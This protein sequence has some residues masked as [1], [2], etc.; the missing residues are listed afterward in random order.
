[1][2][3]EALAYFDRVNAVVDAML[4][5]WEEVPLYSEIF[6]DEN[7]AASAAIEKNKEIGEKATGLLQKAI[8]KLKALFI[9]I[10]DAIGNA[11]EYFFASKEEKLDFDQFLKAA[12]EDPDLANKKV[13]FRDYRGILASMDKDIKNW[14]NEYTKFKES[15][16]ENNPS[17]TKT[18][19]SK[20]DEYTSTVGNILKGAGATVGM[21]VLLNAAKMN[22]Q[23]AFIIQ[24]AI[25]YDIGLLEAL[26]KQLG[27][28]RA[29]KFKK[30]IAKLNSSLEI[31]RKIHGGRELQGKTLMDA[32]KAI[33]DAQVLDSD[34]KNSTGKTVFSMLRMYM[35]ARGG[36]NKGDFKK[37][38]RGVIHTGVEG[39]KTAWK[40][41]NIV[42]EPGR[43]Q[44][45][46]DKIDK[47]A[48]RVEAK[49]E[50][51]K[52]RS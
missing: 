21:E 30:E 41:H 10:K 17:L 25:N 14:E 51:M 28:A 7:G 46:A 49:N 44:K 8:S 38:E 36:K 13:R 9:K 45:K 43:Q 5:E 48:R 18:I 31:V 39:V 22:R 11:L 2:L 33:T 52:N 40:V 32:F 16:A 47:K 26:E 1:M 20:M 19:S 12:K 50:K 37:A 29:K 4:E 42:G 23:N 15:A 3:L 27:V 24:Q 6:E 34:A 35:T